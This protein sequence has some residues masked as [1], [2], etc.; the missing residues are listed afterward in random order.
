MKKK[1]ELLFEEATSWK[2]ANVYRIR[3]LR[4]IPTHGVK[5]GD[6]GGFIESEDNLNQAGRAWVGG[7]AKVFNESHID[8]D[9]LVTG[10]AQINNTR[11][12]GRIT[13][14]GTC[15]LSDSLLYGEDLHI[16]G[17]CQVEYV[18]MKVFD[19][20]FQG[21]ITLRHI[22]GISPVRQ[23]VIQE[24]AWLIGTEQQPVR[25]AG[26]DIE[27][28][29]CSKLIRIQELSGSRIVVTD[30]ANVASDVSINGDDITIGG[31]ARVMGNI[32]LGNHLSFM[33]FSGIQGD[34]RLTCYSNMRLTGENQ[35]IEPPM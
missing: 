30:F 9:V 33:D 31:H 29:G 16:M 1:Y 3:A 20:L 7:N 5:T 10:E 19:G 14:D 23:L 2:G 28:S 15:S 32:Q 13:V 6:L 21:R 18:E 12:L 11:L 4:D 26:E 8:G 25:I 17:S 27:L 35:I 34:D 22:R 24:D